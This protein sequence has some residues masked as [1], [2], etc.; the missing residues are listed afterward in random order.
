MS[1]LYLHEW[2]NPNHRCGHLQAGLSQGSRYPLAYHGLCQ[3]RGAEP[4]V[5][6][7]SPRGGVGGAAGHV[8]PPLHRCNYRCEERERFP[9]RGGSGE[10]PPGR[11]PPRA[12]GRC[13]PRGEER[14]RL[15]AGRSRCRSRPR[16]PPGRSLA[17]GRVTRAS[18][19]RARASGGGRKRRPRCAGRRERR[20][21]RPR[22]SI[23][24]TSP[25]GPSLPPPPPPLGRIVPRPPCM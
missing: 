1:S 6:L 10:G 24:A 11:A 18:R 23:R 20:W 3:S 12:A 22:P 2:Q 19:S 16:E 7:P 14:Q 5:L 15:P 21:A 4:G 8:L 17:A 13:E 9:G 25:N